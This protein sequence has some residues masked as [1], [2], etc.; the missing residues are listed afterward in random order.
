MFSPFFE[1]YDGFPYTKELQKK[2]RELF[3]NIYEKKIA[4]FL[5]TETQ[6]KYAGAVLTKDGVNPYRGGDEMMG[7]LDYFIESANIIEF[8]R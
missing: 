5:K 2:Y 4:E 3:M 1:N 7:N 6:Q 8:H